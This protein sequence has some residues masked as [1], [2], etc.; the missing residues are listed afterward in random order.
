M[1]PLSL[2]RHLQSANS[3]VLLVFNPYLPWKSD[4]HCFH[5]FRFTVDWIG[6]A[7]APQICP[8]HSCIHFRSFNISYCISSLASRFC[9]PR[10]LDIIQVTLW[11]LPEWPV[12]TREIVHQLGFFSTLKGVCIHLGI[13]GASPSSWSFFPQIFISYQQ[14]SS[15]LGFDL[16]ST[17]V[18]WSS[19]SRVPQG[20][21]CILG[22]KVLWMLCRA[23][24][25]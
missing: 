1:A 2:I 22:L 12:N 25:S 14:S 16:W 11:V 13:K 19:Q 8:P 23:L 18:Y 24:G 5:P 20:L 6:A 3:P 7:V 15:E 21:R 17:L 9:L 10:S 4:S